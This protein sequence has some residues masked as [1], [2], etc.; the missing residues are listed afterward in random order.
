MGNPLHMPCHKARTTSVT[1][2][3]HKL[4]RRWCTR[5]WRGVGPRQRG[6]GDEA[7]KARG[8]KNGHSSSFATQRRPNIVRSRG[9][10]VDADDC[11]GRMLS[12]A[13]PSPGVD[14]IVT[15]LP[16]WGWGGGGVEPGGSDDGM[17]ITICSFSSSDSSSSGS[18]DTV[19]VIR[20]GAGGGGAA[21]PHYIHPRPSPLHCYGGDPVTPAPA[22]E[23][24]RGQWGLGHRGTPVP[25]SRTR[26]F[27]SLSGCGPAMQTISSR[28]PTPACAL[29]NTNRHTYSAFMAPPPPPTHTQAAGCSFR[30]C[31]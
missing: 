10:T 5:K 1:G 25:L 20:G 31:R 24:G 14:I 3:R 27:L 12:H 18:A 13:A 6:G 30:P 7:A 28:Q 19:I 9:G 11:E 23:A 4:L 15:T 22:G 17:T 8:I 2:G 26:D 29:E 21:P 16:G